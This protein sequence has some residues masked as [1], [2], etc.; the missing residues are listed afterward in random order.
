MITIY[1][2]CRCCT[3]D[4]AEYNVSL[5]YMIAYVPYTYLILKIINFQFVLFY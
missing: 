5:C 4:F 2:P 3:F 1:T